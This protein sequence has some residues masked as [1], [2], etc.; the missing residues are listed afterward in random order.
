MPAVNR[1]LEGNACRESGGLAGNA[2]R[3]AG[4]LAGNVRW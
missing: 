4:G 1:G 3:Q 2:C